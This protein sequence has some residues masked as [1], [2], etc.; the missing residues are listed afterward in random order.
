LFLGIFTDVSRSLAK[1]PAGEDASSNTI[2]P[3]LEDG[4]VNTVALEDGCGA[5]PG[6]SSAHDDYGWLDGVALFK[7]G[8]EGGGGQ[9]GDLKRGQVG[10]WIDNLMDMMIYFFWI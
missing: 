2:L 1:L 10:N 5:K 4:D 9:A 7:F 6:D 3:T 8:W